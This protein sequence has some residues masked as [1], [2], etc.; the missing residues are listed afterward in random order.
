MALAKIAVDLDHYK[1]RMQ[2]R[3]VPWSYNCSKCDRAVEDHCFRR[4]DIVPESCEIWYTE[5]VQSP[6]CLITPAY[7]RQGPH[8]ACYGCGADCPTY[9]YYV[10]RLKQ[11]R[12]VL[13]VALARLM[14][15]MK[16][17]PGTC[18][19]DHDGIEEAAAGGGGEEVT[20]VNAS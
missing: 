18:I 20:T 17:E 12:H 1:S 13:W 9:M 5:C 19:L 14:T 3:L 8:S 7:V 2:S 15:A 6:Q 16:M 11:Y 10:T 4:T